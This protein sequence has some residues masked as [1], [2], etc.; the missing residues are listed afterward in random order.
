VPEGSARLR[1]NLTAS[2]ERQDIDALAEALA[3]ARDAGPAEPPGKDGFG[4]D[5]DGPDA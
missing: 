5:G 4:R 3:A 2:I 1:I